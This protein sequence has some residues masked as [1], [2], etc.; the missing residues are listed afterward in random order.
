MEPGLIQL[1][2]AIQSEEWKGAER[3]KEYIG[4]RI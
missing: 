4:T 1:L 3:G 2:Y